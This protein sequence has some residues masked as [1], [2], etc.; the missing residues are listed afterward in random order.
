M[1]LA[2]RIKIIRKQLE[3]SQTE[4]A[5]AIGITQTS[6]SQIE[7]EKNGISY[8]VYK[9]IV[10][11]FNVDPLWLM[12]GKGEMYIS[13][14]AKKKS[15]ALPL[16]VQISGDEEENIVMVDRKAAAGYLQGQSDPDYIAKL[17]SFRLP[18][19]YGKTFRAFEIIGDSMLPGIHPGDMLVGG[20][21]EELAHIKKGN[22][23]IVVMHDGS[24]V[25]KRINPLGNNVFE[26]RSDNLVY[27]AYAVKAED[28]GQV[29]QV[30]ARITK[31]IDKPDDNRFLELEMRL[32]DLETKIK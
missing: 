13:N 16:V 15:G 29:W 14:E 2:Q 31:D 10:G 26:L 4:F 21:V 3:M 24:I 18:G 9:A 7:G 8:D 12:D 27:E 6:L 19:F 11:K 28:I 5:N 32:K 22:V 25:A 20:Y 23:Y 17:P 1:T 30:E